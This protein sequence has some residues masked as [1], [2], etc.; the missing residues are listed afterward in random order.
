MVAWQHIEWLKVSV[1]SVWGA[2]VGIRLI[3]VQNQSNS[4]YCRKFGTFLTL[5]WGMLSTI[6]LMVLILSNVSWLYL[7][8]QFL[9]GKP[10]EF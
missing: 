7:K 2:V 5:R 10:Q 4:M 9:V 8:L 1:E 3:G 6:L